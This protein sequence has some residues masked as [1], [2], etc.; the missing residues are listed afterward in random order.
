MDFD[1]TL[2][3]IQKLGL[4]TMPTTTQFKSAH[5]LRE[6]EGA[7]ASAVLPDETAETV[8]IPQKTNQGMVILV[9]YYNWVGQPNRYTVLPPHYAM[10]MEPVTGKVLRFWSCRPLELG[11]RIPTTP[12]KGAGI[13]P[14]M[15]SDEFFEKRQRFLDISAEVWQAY[16]SG[17]TKFDSIIRTIVQEYENLFLQ[18]TKEEVAPFYVAAS[19]DFFKW[20]QIVSQR[21]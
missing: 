10:Q 9:M 7:T 6:I 5:E 2:V 14:N 17:K 13:S 11:I 16:A 18:I 20:L 4:E 3:I 12:V 19:P 15:T 1:Y 21:R 8:P